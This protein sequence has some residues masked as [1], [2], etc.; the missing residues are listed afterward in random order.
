[1]IT[2]E[3]RKSTY[4]NAHEECVEVAIGLRDAVV[5]RDSKTPTGPTLHLSP[6]AWADFRR[7]VV[8]GGFGP[9]PRSDNR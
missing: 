6:A 3:Y 2:S 5:I 4:S 9:A 7:A 1:M 8:G